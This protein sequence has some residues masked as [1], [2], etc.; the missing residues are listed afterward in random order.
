MVQTVADRRLVTI[1]VAEV[2][3]YS[4]LIG[5]D[6]S[7]TLRRLKTL[8][9]EVIE[10]AVVSAKGRIIKTVGDGFIAEFGSAVRAVS[11]AVA[12]Q[13]GV[14]RQQAGVAD[15]RALRLR[16]RINLGDVVVEP[17]GHLYGDGI[18]IAAR[19]EPL[20]ETGGICGS[21]KYRWISECL[22]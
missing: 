1:L 8:R 6:E 7:G 17:D 14:S 4:R 5:L 19:L 15:D 11:C 2:V 18:N 12:I 10:P 20:A 3:G 9:R 21:L 13:Q 16:I 22:I